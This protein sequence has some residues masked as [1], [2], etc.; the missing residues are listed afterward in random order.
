M[1]PISLR[2]KLS[3]LLA[4]W[5]GPHRHQGPNR[6][7]GG[8]PARRILV[9][10][11][12]KTG[13]R[14]MRNLFAAVCEEH[15]LRFHGGS[16]SEA[17]A[18]WDLLFEDHSQFDRRLLATPF[19]GLHLI[20]DPRD[21]VISGAFY[22]QHATE[23][24]L[25]QPL[26]VLG[27]ESYQA[28]LNARATLDERIAFEMEYAA[29]HTLGEM[30]AWRYTDPRFF[31]AKYEDLIADTDLHLFRGVFLFLGFPRD[32]LDRTLEIVYRNSLFSG[33]VQD[34]GHVRSGR[35]RQWEHYF[36]AAHGRMFL[37]LFG[38]ALIRLGYERD[39]AS[40]VPCLLADARLANPQTDWT[41]FADRLGRVREAPALR[42]RAESC[43]RS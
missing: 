40:N 26:P 38:N 14:W 43:R 39:N 24:W 8:L 11:H 34:P 16:G 5:R 10:T 18:N 41:L 36:T 4:A 19:R 7:P 21:I 35:P 30:L 42:S 27:G 17:P 13:S 20:R 3:T 29:R 23:A 1:S 2:D 6:R 33:L 22:H 9:G 28:A 32:R 12:H 31:E 15:S 37:D 25:T